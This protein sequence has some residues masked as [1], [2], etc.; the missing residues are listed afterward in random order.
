MVLAGKIIHADEAL[1]LGIVDYLVPSKDVLDF[2]LNL[3]EKITARKIGE[4]N[5]FDHEVRQ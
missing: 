1:E 3:L 4:Y 5:S 2:S